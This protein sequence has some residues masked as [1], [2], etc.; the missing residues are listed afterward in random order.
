MFLGEYEYRVDDKGRLP[1]PPKFRQEFRDG[2][3]LTRGAETCIVVYPIAEWQKLADT[4]AARTV[5]PS[6]LRRLNRVIFGA[7]F[8]LTL[9]GQGRIALPSPLRRYAEIGDVATIVGANNCIELWDSA[10]WNSE[11]ASAEEQAWQIIESLEGQP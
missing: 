8:S 9:D 2:I 4:L 3:I 5:T 11:K 10:L 7:A 6:K 1:L